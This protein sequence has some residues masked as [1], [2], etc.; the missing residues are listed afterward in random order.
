[1]NE[2]VARVAAMSNKSS[3]AR[4][5]RRDFRD[6][7]TTFPSI[8]NAFVRYNTKALLSIFDRRN[9]ITIVNAIEQPEV[10]NHCV[11]VS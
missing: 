2:Q 4:I 3:P 1:M 7:F 8:E 9:Q 5:E 11:P 6:R 10:K